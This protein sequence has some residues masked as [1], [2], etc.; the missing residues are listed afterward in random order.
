MKAVIIE[1]E[2]INAQELI[3]KLATVAEDVEVIEVLPS[4]K[5]AKRWL[6]NNTEPDLLFMD[7]QLSDGIS[8]EIFD[9]YK[10]TC[11][12]IF[13][14]AY[15]EYALRAFKVNSVDYLLKPV[16]VN[17]LKAALEKCRRLS[18]DNTRVPADW[19]EL[20]RTLT[21]SAERQPMY[22]EKFIVHQRQQWIPVFTKDIA[23]FMRDSL[24]FLI[25]FREEKF[26]LDFNSLEEIEDIIDPRVFFR[27]NRQ[28]IINT[29]AIASIRLHDNGKLSLH[30]KSPLKSV[31][32]VSREKAPSF[33]RWFEQ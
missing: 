29:N 30:L 6:M 32:E 19:E 20:L 7:I 8:F 25:T 9:Q 26:Y 23:Y 21:G 28:C 13:T 33:K 1:D 2:A 16:N 10:I 4:V 22:R 12:I 17:E 24:N 11:P 3:K 5:A 27:A 14:T 15:D 31:I 18:K